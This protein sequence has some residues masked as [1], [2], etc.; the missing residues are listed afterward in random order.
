MTVT[1]THNFNDLYLGNYA[2]LC[3]FSLRIVGDGNIAED[4]VEEVFVS[5]LNSK[6]DFTETDNLK[7]WLYTVTRNSSLNFLRSD[8][9]SKERQFQFTSA[10]PTEESAYIYEMIRTEALNLILLEIKKL[11]GSSGKI[12]ELSYLKGMKNDQIAELMG[13]SVKTVKNLKSIGM[14]RLKAHL[15]PDTYLLLLLLSSTA[16]NSDFLLNIAAR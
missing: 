9:R 6:K 12:I 13:L 8:K 2:A 4:I 1:P 16:V 14:A 15:S 10:Q 7:A 5:L 3:Y 11:P